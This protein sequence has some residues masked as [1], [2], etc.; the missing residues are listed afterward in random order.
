MPKLRDTPVGISDLEEY[1]R[2]H[3][4]FAL[5]LDLFQHALELNATAEHGGT[6]VDRATGKHRQFDL[7][8][9]VD[10]PDH[11]VFLAVECKN[12]GSNF[13]LLVSRIPRE[14]TEAFHEVLYSYT[15]R[16]PGTSIGMPRDRA[17]VLVVSDQGGLCPAGRPVGKSV[18]Q[19]G[20]TSQ[21]ELTSGDSDTYEKWSQAPSSAHDLVG[22]ALVACEITGSSKCLSVVL[23]VLVVGDG[24][25]WTVD[26]NAA[27]SPI[28]SPA[29]AEEAELFIDRSYSVGHRTLYN[30]SHLHIYTRTRFRTFLSDLV[31]NE[32]L[33]RRAFPHGLVLE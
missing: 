12:I 32:M 27:G 9:R 5:E 33:F 17:Q 4:D 16:A 2:D 23:P 15:H 18:T 31:N 14:R 28:G 26:Y 13:P 19:V 7:R 29:Q 30:V 6:Y 22:R 8:I 25:L 3:D 11:L 1:L 10:A 24:T 20:R 21:G